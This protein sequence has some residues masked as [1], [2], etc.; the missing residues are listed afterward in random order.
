M[1]SQSIH[2][3]EGNVSADSLLLLVN[4]KATGV[5]RVEDVSK[6]MPGGIDTHQLRRIFPAR[7]WKQAIV[8]HCGTAPGI[9]DSESLVLGSADWIP[10]ASAGDVFQL[11]L[12][13]WVDEAK[14]SNAKRPP[15]MR[16]EQ[17]VLS[18]R[19]KDA[20]GL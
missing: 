16:R 19:L 14:Q 1:R 6:T 4:H 15:E 5:S 8:A 12:K 3:I 20:S 13:N 17:E 10:F 7:Q 11:S 18:K 9:S 2:E